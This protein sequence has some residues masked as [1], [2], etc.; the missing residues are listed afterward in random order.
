MLYDLILLVDLDKCCFSCLCSYYEICQFFDC[1]VE[2]RIRN[3]C[4]LAK[5]VHG[6]CL[7]GVLS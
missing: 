3:F 2:C 1:S 7:V 5:L 4:E 6:E